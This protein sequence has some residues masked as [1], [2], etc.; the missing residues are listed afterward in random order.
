MNGRKM[1][2]GLVGSKAGY[3]AM[4]GC[5]FLPFGL[6]C[7]VLEIQATALIHTCEWSPY[8]NFSRKL[9]QGEANWDF[10]TLR[11]VGTSISTQIMPSALT[12]RHSLILI[13]LERP[14][15]DHG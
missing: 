4:T 15:S 8:R 7:L 6:E 9:S 10:L 11:G 1:S 3:R 2:R 5:C 13:F 12:P 14:G